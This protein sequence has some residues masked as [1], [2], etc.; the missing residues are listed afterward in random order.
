MKKTNIE[1]RYRHKVK[2]IEIKT[3]I[4]KQKEREKGAK[5]A[6]DKVKDREKMI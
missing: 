1:H 3:K 5:I 6:R 4:E 2:E